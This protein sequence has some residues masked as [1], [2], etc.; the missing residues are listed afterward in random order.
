VT[1]T[2]TE[3]TLQKLHQLLEEGQSVEAAALIDTSPGQFAGDPRSLLP[4]LDGLDRQRKD[5]ALLGIVTKLRKH[6]IL[7]L[8]CMIFELR[9]KFRDGSYPQALRLIDRILGLAANNIEALR[10][11]GR[12]GNLTRNDGRAL[13]YWERLAAAAPSD[14][15]AALQAARIHL[16]QGHHAQALSHA[17]QAA[18]RRSDTA[19]PLQIAVS[20]GLAS[21]WSEACD[22]LLARL[23]TADRARAM[24]ALSRLV[25]ELDCERTARLLS[26]LQ[27][28]VANDPALNGVSTKAYSGWLA[29]ALEQELASRE[30][31][32]AAYYRAVRILRP[33]DANAQRALERLSAPSLLAMREAFD[34]RDFPGAVEHGLMATR[35]NPECLE[36]WQVVGRAQFTRGNSAEAS[37]AF[38]RCTTLDPEDARSWLMYGLVLNQAGER[39]PALLAFQKARGLADLEVRKEA[40]VSIAALQPLLVRDARQ[41]A[42]DGNIDLAWESADA[43]LTARP[44]DVGMTQLRQDLLRQHKQKI[45]DAWNTTSD[46]VAPLCRHYLEKAPGDSYVS[47]VLARTLMRTR[48]YGEALPLWENL[49]RQTPG[50]SHNHL[51]VARCCRSLKIKE[52]GLA[53]AQTALRL[54]PGLQEAAEVAEFLKALPPPAAGQVARR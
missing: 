14:P 11:G 42:N 43:A 22:P 45:R 27:Q 9:V 46:T 17:Q 49:S 19:E 36:A 10:T 8:E 40:E 12:I 41:A 48:A 33:H 50:D 4:L 15:E 51:Q 44:E 2:T 6:D 52:R 29:T 32:A 30:L 37:D 25:E 13:R 38:R 5:E 7:L 34:S 28:Q 20:A 54:D 53:A 39:R 35:I 47:T 31:D 3:P 21:G 1:D 18:E 24:T 16:R 23:F 26:L